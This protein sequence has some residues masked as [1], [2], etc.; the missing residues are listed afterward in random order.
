MRTRRRTPPPTTAITIIHVVDS[1]GGSTVGVKVVAGV[2]WQEN[3]AR[4]SVTVATKSFFSI[5]LFK[6]P[7]LIPVFVWRQQF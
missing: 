5:D 7:S 3:S 4:H 1:T 2:V 6:I